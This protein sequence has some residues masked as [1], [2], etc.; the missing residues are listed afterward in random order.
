MRGSGEKGKGAGASPGGEGQAQ[1]WNFIITEPILG[2]IAHAAPW[3]PKA[4]RYVLY[5]TRI[6]ALANLAGVP[7]EIPEGMSCVLSLMV[8]WKA[9]ARVDQDNVL[10]AVTDSMFKRDRGIER[11]LCDRFEHTGREEISVI[12]GF[13][14]R[15]GKRGKREHPDE[16]GVLPR[17][18]L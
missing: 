10:K 12:V 9:K 16:K 3:L 17:N 7:D 13:K 8:A 6:R 11:V 1:A 15:Q 14:A 18:L 4:K 2:F 5:K